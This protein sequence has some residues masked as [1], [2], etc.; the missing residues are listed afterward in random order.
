M[1]VVLLAE[2]VTLARRVA[3]KFI[4][5][6]L[7]DAG[8]RRRFV[9]EA[10][11]MARVSHPNVLQIHAFG[12]HDGAPYFVMEFVQGVTLAKRLAQREPVEIDLALRIMGQICA[13]V[14]AI[15][16]AETV[17]RDLKPSNV[18]L[19][20]DLRA[21]VA[22]L[23]LA[24]LRSEARGNRRSVVGTPTYMAP[25]VA[26]PLDADDSMAERAD[27]YS[28]ACVA[29][30]LVTGQTPFVASGN[31]AMML[32]HASSAVV[33]PS[34]V[35][36]GLPAVLDEVILRGLAKSPAD[37]T[38][39]AAALGAAFEA[40]RAGLSHPAHVLI[41]HAR[42]EGRSAL[43]VAFRSAFPRA[44]VE[45]VRDVAAAV[46]AFDRRRPSVVIF[47]VALPGRGGLTLARM[48]RE[49][50]PD[51]VVPMI[52]I[53]NARSPGAWA[54]LS[55]LGVDRIVA[56]PLAVGE[57]VTL[58]NLLLRQRVRAARLPPR[59]EGAAED[60]GERTTDVTP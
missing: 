35:R 7:R 51:A 54:P 32:Q 25:E 53:A 2:D 21:R 42:A 31:A 19:D 57:V 11:A 48:L 17:H 29:Y 52:A 50:D 30:E 44:I 6:N 59:D 38:A 13:G 15:H 28:L 37:R 43:A 41:A 60:S 45:Q 9:M 14:A 36:P 20:V 39:S 33:P 55:A 23:G 49:R 22:D 8:F 46:E 27:V 3:I 24:R 1:G 58:V 12:D 56:K 18:L 10:R 26:F 4:R 34:A 5:A 40:A 16:A 47:D